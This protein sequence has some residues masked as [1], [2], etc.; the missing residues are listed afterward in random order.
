VKSIRVE[1]QSG[2]VLPEEGKATDEEIEE[3]SDAKFGA[4]YNLSADAKRPSH[5]VLQTGSNARQLRASFHGRTAISE[6]KAMR[7]RCNLVTAISVR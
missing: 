2:Y 7:S 3:V 6:R 5:T 4:S 1:L